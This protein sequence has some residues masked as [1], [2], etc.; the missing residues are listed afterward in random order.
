MS[1]IGN[2]EGGVGRRRWSSEAAGTFDFF[3]AIVEKGENG[4]EEI[5]LLV[6]R[7]TGFDNNRSRGTARDRNTN[8]H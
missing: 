8:M 3:L 1:T 6:R 2:V 7:Y 5:G 4:F